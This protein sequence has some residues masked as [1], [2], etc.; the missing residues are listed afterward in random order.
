MKVVR[1]TR[2]QVIWTSPAVR[3]ILPLKPPF[4]IIIFFTAHLCLRYLFLPDW[5]NIADY[6][7]WCVRVCL[8]MVSEE[9][10]CRTTSGRKASASIPLCA[11]PGKRKKYSE[12]WSIGGYHLHHTAFVQFWQGGSGFLIPTNGAKTFIKETLWGINPFLSLFSPFVA[13]FV[14]GSL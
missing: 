12:Y 6:T 13:F 8:R 1:V 10:M 3:K 14:P 4:A 11:L 7:A 9:V 2:A 5:Y